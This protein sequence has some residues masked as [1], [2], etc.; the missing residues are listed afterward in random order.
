LDLV[1]RILRV[2]CYFCSDLLLPE[3]GRERLRALAL[4]E[5]K[6]CLAL[7]LSLSKTRRCCQACGGHN[8]SFAK[9]GLSIRADFSRVEF[10]D[11]EE[12]EYCRRAFTAG[13]A[14]TILRN[15]SDE[16]CLLLGLEP[17]RSRPETFILSAL[18]VPPPAIRPCTFLSDAN[19]SRGQDDLTIKLSDIVKA[20]NVAR[21]VLQHEAEVISQAGLSVAAQQAVAEL[22]FPGRAGL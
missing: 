8:P 5:R 22:T 14:R 9:V 6:R 13:E 21:Q 12:A 16:N 10:A 4:K 7:A 18:V 17:Q 1:L 2:T 20:N 11:E 19:R 3:E 15:I